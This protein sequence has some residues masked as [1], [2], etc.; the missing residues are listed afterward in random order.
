MPDIT[1]CASKVCSVHKRCYRFRAKP[2]K[3]WQS[4]FVD[5]FPCRFGYKYFIRTPIKKERGGSL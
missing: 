3:K 5:K 4:Y 1:M 2:D